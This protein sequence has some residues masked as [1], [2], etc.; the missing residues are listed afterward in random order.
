MTGVPP[1]LYVCSFGYHYR[2][3]P[4]GN[5]VFDVRWLPNPFSTA[6][7]RD[8]SGLDKPVRDWLFAHPGVDV[9]FE[10]LMNALGPQLAAVELKD[11]R[12]VT[13]AFGCAGGHD[14]SVAVA[15]YAATT[16][17]RTGMIVFVDHL[18]IHRRGGVHHQTRRAVIR[19]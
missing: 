11:S 14:R 9:W 19:G 1:I 7:F 17:R 5:A 15:E 6:E 13:W 8:L 16:I 3:P 10:S 2:T 18:D 12:A 4:L